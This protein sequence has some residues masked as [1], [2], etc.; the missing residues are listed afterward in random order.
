[1]RLRQPALAVAKREKVDGAEVVHW[2]ARF[3]QLRGHYAFHA[4]ACTPATPREKGAVEG[5]VRHHKTGFWPAR[6]FI[7]LE[8]LD[9]AYAGWR[10]RVAL[11]RRHATG[12][13]IVAE[14]LAVERNAL[15]ALPP[16]DFD[17]AGRRSSRVPVDG[18]LK[19]GRCFYRARAAGSSARRAALGTATGSG[20]STKAGGSPATPAATSTAPGSPPHGCGPS[21]PRS[22]RSS[23][24]RPRRSPRRRLRTTPSSAHEP[25]DQTGRRATALPAG[26]A[27]GPTSPGALGPDRRG[28][29]RRGLAL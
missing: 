1:M 9:A 10:D 12:G 29:P 13:H 4:T 15:R 27:Q 23:P 16:V 11:P 5:A 2:N 26:Q 17:A 14:R 8:E 7:T 21:R 20:S 19:H 3:S 18:Y 6:P 28:R 25:K 24:S 22:P